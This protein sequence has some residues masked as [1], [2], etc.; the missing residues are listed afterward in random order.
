MQDSSLTSKCLIETGAAANVQYPLRDA[1]SVAQQATRYVKL[2]T[3]PRE[4]H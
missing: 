3:E 2:Y 1:Y 4:N